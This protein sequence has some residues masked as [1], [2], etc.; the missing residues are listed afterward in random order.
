MQETTFEVS[1]AAEAWLE[2]LHMHFGA[3]LADALPLI[4]KAEGHLRDAERA[5]EELRRQC[6]CTT[7]ETSTR[8]AL[9]SLRM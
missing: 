1:L 5:E 9:C 2:M 4:A 7:T 3:V 6:A 8:H